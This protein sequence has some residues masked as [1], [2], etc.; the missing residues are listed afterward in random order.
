ME[1]THLLLSLLWMTGYK[2]SHKKAQ[3]CQDTVKYLQFHL[4]QG[5]SGL[6]PERKQAICSIPALRTHQQIR[7]VLEAS[8]FY[9]ICIP[10]FSLLAKPL[11]KVTQGRE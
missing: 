5:Q 9:W 6:D 3:I 1:G 2:V 8:G 4:S 11:Y 7:E 10:N